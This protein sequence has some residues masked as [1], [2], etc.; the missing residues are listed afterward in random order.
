ML[1]PGS[2]VLHMPPR[3]GSPVIQIRPLDS[4]GPGGADLPNCF[5]GYAS[6]SAPPL[7]AT[8]RAARHLMSTR[9][10]TPH[11]L[12][13]GSAAHHTSAVGTST[14]LEVDMQATQ[15]RSDSWARRTST[16]TCLTRTRTRKISMA[17]RT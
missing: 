16:T 11:L 2:P 17:F 7:R 8:L 14:L 15:Q 4:V 10:T 12:I 9:A 3:A 5:M 6:A 13:A 1:R